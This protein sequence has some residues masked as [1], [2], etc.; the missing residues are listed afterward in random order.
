MFLTM[1]E[2][3]RFISEAIKNPGSFTAWVE[4]MYG[5]AGFT[6]SKRTGRLVIKPSIILKAAKGRCPICD[7]PRGRCICPSKLTVQQARLARTLLNINE[8]RH[9]LRRMRE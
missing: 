6:K 9:E 8:K 5:K 1:A 4:R 7:L 2:G 3:E